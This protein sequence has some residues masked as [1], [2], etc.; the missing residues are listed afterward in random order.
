[1]NEQNKDVME[2]LERF[3]SAD[4]IIKKEMNL[5]YPSDK[6]SDIES[7]INYT[8]SAYESLDYVISKLK[9]IAKDFFEDSELLNK[10]IEF[11]ELSSK[12]ALIDSKMD[13]GKLKTFY[14]NYVSDMKPEFIDNVKKECFGYRLNR[15]SDSIQLANTINEILYFMHS[16]II[17]ND[18]ILQEIPIMYT[19]S[20]LNDWPINLRGKIENSN[21]LKLYKDFPLEL[22]CGITDMIIVSKNKLIMM[23]RDLGHAL[24]TEIT[25]NNDKARIEY[26]IPKLCNI[27]MINALPGINK[28]NENSVGATGA[29]E[30]SVENLP[31]T[32]YD[33]LSKVPT[34]LDIENN[35]LNKM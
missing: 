5:L 17:N 28:V 18:L 8:D 13:L 30:I 4:M 25:I 27:N 9:S 21:F 15:T 29:I 19:K 6:Y 11:L 31:N 7:I 26:F 24:T 10:K 34:D 1:M 32:L 3:F 23:V 20:N 2:K 16:S 35:D 12:K 14:T 33:F 22:G